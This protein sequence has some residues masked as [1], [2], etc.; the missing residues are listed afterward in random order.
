MIEVQ[1]E[2]QGRARPLHLLVGLFDGGH[3]N[4][5]DPR[6]ALLKLV[7]LLF[8]F[9]ERLFGAIATGEKCVDDI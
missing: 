1:I 3:E 8:V 4:R 5:L 7:G 6:S 9:G 2:P